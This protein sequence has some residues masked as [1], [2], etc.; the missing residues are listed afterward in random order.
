MYLKSLKAIG[1]KSFADRTTLNF[2]PGITAIVG[3]NGCGKS[4]ISDAIRWVLG[5]QS[6]KALRG[7]EMADVIFSG[8]DGVR[9]RK[10]TGMAEVS[11]T[12]GDVDDENLKAAG[13][14]LNYNEVTVT[15]RVFRDGGSEYFLNGTGCRLRDVQ[16]LFMGTGIGRNSYSIMAQGQITQIIQSR[17]QERRMVFEEA[18]GI[19][20]FKQQKKEALRK[21]DYT[22]QNLL[23][24]EDT[25]REVKRQ[26]GSLQRQ[27]GKAR[28]FQKIMDKLRDMETR[29]ARHEFDTI[30]LDLKGIREEA[31]QI[32]TNLENH[33]TGILDEEAALKQIRSALSNLDQQVNTVQQQNMELKSETERHENRTQFNEQRMAELDE[34]HTGAE[35]DIAGAQERCKEVDAELESINQ[36]LADSDHALERARQYVT[37]KRAVVEDFDTAIQSR[38]SARS[39]THVEASEINEQL[40]RTRNELNALELQKQGNV[41]RLEKLSA[42]KI[43]LEEER[44]K[45]E[46]S[47]CEFEKS[48][49]NDSLHVETHRGTV[50]ER[51]ARLVE[52]GS[53]LIE[54][55]DELDELL[56]RQA[57]AKSRRDVLQQLIET[58][59]GFSAGAQTVLAEFDSAIGSL[60][61]LI[62]VP[63]EHV[64]AIEAAMGSNLQLVLTEQS[65]AANEML[66]HLAHRKQGRTGIVA[67]ELLRE[68]GGEIPP[69]DLPA[70]GKPAL[71]VVETDERN[72]P[73]LQ[74]LLGRTLIVD[75]LETATRLWRS[76]P[77]RFDFVTRNG[78]SLSQQGIYTGGNSNRNE[79]DHSSILARRNQVD[80][81]EHQLT[82][83]GRQID[84][85]SRNKGQL[86]GE[87]TE[88]QASLQNARD[89]LSDRKV[90]IATRQGE[91]NALQ[92]SK[93]VLH[94]KIDTVVFEIQNLA[95]QEAGAKGKVLDLSARTREMEESELTLK[96]ET[97]AHDT[98]FHEHRESRESALEELTEAKVALSKAEE[99]GT[100]LLDQKTPMEQ[101]LEEL[102]RTLE[103]A[104][105]TLSESAERKIQFIAQNV[106]SR[107][108]IDRLRIERESANAQVAELTQQRN[109]QA[110]EAERREM[111]LS[112]RRTSHIEMQERKGEIEVELTQKRMTQEQLVERIREKYDLDL[113]NIQGEV[114]TIN[115]TDNGLTTTETNTPE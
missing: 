93:Q 84:E 9:G 106:E 1:F 30:E 82:N 98:F 12:I 74:T 66:S 45:L 40:T 83:L 8:T 101:R 20:K 71:Q 99:R 104:Q 41:A 114:T 31:D 44:A 50:E 77:G 22:A 61:D 72:Q 34:Q 21:L 81:L 43:Q 103:R 49:E 64:R 85:A 27:A 100:S 58:K 18:A 2:E 16:Q 54:A 39:E 97:S 102:Q 108:E 23:R 105:K 6:A 53:Q 75:T 111:D 10:P 47:L 13:V 70:E 57:E 68:R 24:L 7:G 109:Q 55:E 25:I 11:I 90:A 56:R 88:L 67:L 113:R 91:F 48:V 115:I 94:Q 38:Q 69:N 36:Q 62:R 107:R 92:K 59:E 33:S 76:N 110:A 28:R 63:D 95:E 35:S 46:V 80:D 79:D 51:Q 14:D 19:T 78:E 96:A 15:R 73:L 65:Q 17:P 52:L 89:E 112:D 87:Q 86:L 5:E 32:R 26:I 29:L 4:N 60:S 37:G 3:P 42:E